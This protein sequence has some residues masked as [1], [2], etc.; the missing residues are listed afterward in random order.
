MERVSQQGAR[1]RTF[2]EQN[3]QG[4]TRERLAVRESIK[5]DPRVT[6]RGPGPAPV[7]ANAGDEQE[8]KEKHARSYR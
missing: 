6:W 7:P 1:P 8:A 5:G 3:P 4:D 2:T